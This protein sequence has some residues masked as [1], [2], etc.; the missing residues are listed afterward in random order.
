MLCTC[1]RASQAPAVQALVCS[2]AGILRAGVLLHPVNQNISQISRPSEAKKGRCSEALF[3]ARLTLQYWKVLSQNSP[4]VWE[5]F[6]P[7]ADE[8]NAVVCDSP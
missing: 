7:R 4:E 8:R 1:N 3:K 2:D 5:A 6:V